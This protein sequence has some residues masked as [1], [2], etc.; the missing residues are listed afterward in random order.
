[1]ASKSADSARIAAIKKAEAKITASMM[2]KRKAD[3]MSGRGAPTPADR[4]RSTERNPSPRMAALIK[5]EAKITADLNKKRAAK[6][7]AAAKF[8]AATAKATRGNPGK[9]GGL[10]G[11][12][13]GGA[14]NPFGRID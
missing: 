8:K 3:G 14:G 9:G 13:I 4:I 5:A 2:K 11:G 12:V 7:A 1:M 6:K 10:R